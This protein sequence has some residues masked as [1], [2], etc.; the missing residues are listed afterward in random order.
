MSVQVSGSM[1]TWMFS[2]T[3]FSLPVAVAFSTEAAAR[4]QAPHILPNS[5]SAGAFVKRL[6]I[7][8]MRSNTSE[9]GQRRNVHDQSQNTEYPHD[10]MMS[11][12]GTLTTYNLIM[13]SW[14][15]EMW[16][17]VVNR[18]LR[19]ITSGPFGMHFATAVATVI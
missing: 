3:G 18:V 1:R 6:I 9:S 14:S 16:Q 7:Q 17:S 19:M 11:I 8:E 5:G 10:K 2:V 15:R 4:A 12:S 13:V